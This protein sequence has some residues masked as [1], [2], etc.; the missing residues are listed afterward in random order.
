V[1]TKEQSQ[2]L[3]RFA[4]QTAKEQIQKSLDT[5]LAAL[6]AEGSDGSNG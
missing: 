5:A 6:D 3:R 2:M 4:V 1:L